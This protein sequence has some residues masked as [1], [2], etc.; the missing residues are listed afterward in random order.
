MR[1]AAPV[2]TSK[3]GKKGDGQDSGL[4]SRSGERSERLELGETLKRKRRTRG[5]QDAVSGESMCHGVVQCLSQFDV[6][7]CL[8]PVWF[9]VFFFFFLERSLAGIALFGCLIE[10]LKKALQTLVNFKTKS[11]RQNQ[12][13]TNKLRTQATTNSGG[14]ASV[15]KNSTALKS[16]LVIRVKGL[17]DGSVQRAPGG[18]GTSRERQRICPRR[19]EQ[20]TTQRRIQW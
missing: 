6:C 18:G 16:P 10:Q 4:Q 19:D 14:K 1:T 15:S 7:L 11:K 12:S 17:Q 2:G 20:D 8:R 13:T 5:R 3:V 9:C